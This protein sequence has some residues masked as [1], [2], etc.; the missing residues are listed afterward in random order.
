MN[1]IP[2]FKFALREDLKDENIFLPVKGEPFSTGFD[3]R[4]AFKDKKD[5]LIKA[6]SYFKIPLGFR[7][8]PEKGWYFQLHPR[9]SSFVKK[10]MHN[11]IGII[12]ESWEGETLFA[13]QYLP[14]P[15]SSATDLVIKYGE[16]VGQIMPAMR[17]EILIHKIS[18]KE[19]DDL[20]EQR[21]YKRKCGGF[22]STG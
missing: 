10:N 5:L 6:G 3:V 11:L 22:G 19:I 4:A 8:L 17:Q 9:S 20:Y 21:D 2:V 15:S 18:N 14:D 7:Y 12:D 13:G 16:P 1:E